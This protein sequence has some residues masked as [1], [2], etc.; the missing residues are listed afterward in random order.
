MLRT[1]TCGELDHGHVGREVTLCGWVDTCRD[2]SGVLFVDLRDRYGRTQVVFSP[3]S[4]RE[5]IETARSLRSEYVIAV[6]GTV[7]LRPEGTVNPKLRTG[8]IEVRARRV[9]ILNPSLTPPFQPGQ[10]PAGRDCD[11]KR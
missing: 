3:E 9:T 5:N 4:G 8:E 2:H 11:D 7:A 10:S 1:H 6:T